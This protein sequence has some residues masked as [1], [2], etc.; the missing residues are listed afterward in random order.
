[1]YLTGG[2][3]LVP[4]IPPGPVPWWL[5]SGSRQC[6]CRVW[7]SSSVNAGDAWL[8]FSRTRHRVDLGPYFR[9]LPPPNSPTC[10]LDRHLDIAARQRVGVVR[11]SVVCVPRSR[12]HIPPRVP[13][14]AIVLSL[15]P[16][17]PHPVSSSQQHKGACSRSRGRSGWYAS[18][19]IPSR[20]W[21]VQTSVLL[22]VVLSRWVKVA[23][24]LLRFI[25][26]SPSLPPPPPPLHAPLGLRLGSA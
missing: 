6:Q 11:V 22:S 1:M 14:L 25:S 17:S 16:G 19:G 13:R 12:F 20:L 4:E 24:S 26:F 23:T 7:C 18:P 10:F 21:T 2:P 8:W 9:P 15:P 5:S 3:C